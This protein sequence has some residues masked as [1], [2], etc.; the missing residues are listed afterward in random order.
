M[1]SPQLQQ[2]Q[3]LHDLICYSVPDNQNAFAGTKDP[4]NNL[5]VSMLA[6]MIA[7]SWRLVLFRVKCIL[8]ESFIIGRED[9]PQVELC[10]TAQKQ[11]ARS[12]PA[13]AGISE[14][15]YQV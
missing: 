3:S 4:S 13:A 9:F 15:V 10:R 11:N 12:I 14:N 1:S 8:K 2:S 6:P 5:F 7:S